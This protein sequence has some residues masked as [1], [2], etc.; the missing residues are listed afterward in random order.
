LTG[1]VVV[2]PAMKSKTRMPAKSGDA[3]DDRL[4]QLERREAELEA[5]VRELERRLKDTPR[6]DEPRTEAVPGWVAPGGS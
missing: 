6:R 3:R 4:A 5:R 2:E 1:S